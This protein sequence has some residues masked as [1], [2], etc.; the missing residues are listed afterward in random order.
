MEFSA[1]VIRTSIQRR[2]TKE[3]MEIMSP[4]HPLWDEF[5]ERLDKVADECDSTENK[6]LARAILE[7][8]PDIEI[9]DS[10]AFFEEYGGYC[11]CEILL[12][13]VRQYEERMEEHWNN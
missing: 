7:S 12:N 3:N 2:Q 4:G 10:F 9:E 11:D 5:V 8:M 1:L 13:I 6:P